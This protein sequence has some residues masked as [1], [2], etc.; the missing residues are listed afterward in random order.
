[1]QGA[2]RPC[3]SAGVK[4]YATKQTIF[5]LITPS[6]SFCSPPPPS[7]PAQLYSLHITEPDPTLELVANSPGLTVLMLAAFCGAVS[8]AR[9]LLERGASISLVN[10]YG[11]TPLMFAAMAGHEEMVSLLLSVGAAPDGVDAW[12]RDAATW[13]EI[14]GYPHIQRLINTAAR[15]RRQWMLAQIRSRSASVALPAT[16]TTLPSAVTTYTRSRPR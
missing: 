9:V 12:G 4:W 10:A 1:M 15:E 11:R 14:R 6:L 2:S 7:R 3:T 16:S 8:A 13:A 5:S